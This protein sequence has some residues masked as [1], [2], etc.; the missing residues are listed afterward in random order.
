MKKK[1]FISRVTSFSIAGNLF[2]ILW[3]TRS[4]INENSNNIFT[5]SLS[6]VILTA[7][8]SLNIFLLVLQEVNQK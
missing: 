2:L 4:A 5:E 3:I 8:F 1:T 6:P 7:F